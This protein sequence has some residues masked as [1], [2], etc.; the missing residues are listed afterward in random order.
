[1]ECPKSL[2]WP[3]MPATNAPPMEGDLSRMLSKPP[4]QRLSNNSLNYI[5]KTGLF[6]LL[7]SWKSWMA[8]GLHIPFSTNSSSGLLYLTASWLLH[9]LCSLPCLH[10]GCFMSTLCHGHLQHH[11]LG[12]PGSLDCRASP[13]V[14]VNQLFS[15]FEPFLLHKVFSP[16]IVLK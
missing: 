5:L 16:N 3:I 13:V 10:V 15:L 9:A 2:F 4:F 6:L 8:S 11:T 7:S 1:M 12:L 14:F